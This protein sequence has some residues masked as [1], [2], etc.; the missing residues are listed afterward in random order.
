MKSIIIGAGKY[1]QVY[2]TYLMEEGI[3]IV[4]FLDDDISTHNQKINNIPVLG[5]VELLSTLKDSHGIEAV[6]CPLGNNYLR[7][8]FLKEAKSLGY[9]TP[10]YIHKSTNISP[11]VIIGDGVYILLGT[12]IMP[13]TI[14]HDYVMISMNVNIAHHTTLHTGVFLSTGCNFGASIEAEPYTYCGI[15][16]TIMTGIHSLGQNC[17]IGAGSVVIKDVPDNAIV[18]GVPAKIIKY[19]TLLTTK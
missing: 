5:S 12:N 17:L 18:A 11:N 8:K 9:K 16:S 1:G 14:I 7:V 15:G 13:D 2:A 10:S 19:K 3:N 4:G 6:Y